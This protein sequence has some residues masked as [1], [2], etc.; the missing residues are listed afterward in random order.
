VNSILHARFPGIL[1]IAEE[2]TSWPNVSRPTDQGGLGFGFKWNMGWM[3]DVLAYF[4]TPPEH[5]RHHHGKLTFGIVYAF[6][7]NYILSLSHDEVVHLKRSLLGKMPGEPWARFA[8]LRLL[9]TF[10]YAHPGKKLLFMGGEI[11]QAGEWDHA[12]ALEWQLLEREPHRALSLF[13]KELNAFYR[14]QP[15]LFEQDFKPIGFEWLDVESADDCTLAFL[16]KGRDPRECLLFAANF[17]EVSLPWHRVGVPYPCAYDLLFHTAAP[18]YGGFGVPPATAV[19]EAEDVPWHGRDF[20]VRLPLPA[21]SAAI[22]RPRPFAA[23]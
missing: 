16:R 22:L 8:N 6:A 7:E 2:S 19:L 4:Q 5:R 9:F 3:H 15:P 23:R 17:S 18:Q 13:C 21:L 20:S 14:S 11:G 12:G 10:M 1:M